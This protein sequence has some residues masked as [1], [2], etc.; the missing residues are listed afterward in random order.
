MQFGIGEFLFQGDD[1]GGDIPIAFFS[2]KM[3]GA[4]LNY[5]VTEKEFLAAVKIVERFRPY[6]ELMLSTVIMT[7]KDVSGRPARRSLALQSFNF[8]F[9]NRKEKD[10]TVRSGRKLC[11]RF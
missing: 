10:N 11:D 6:V 1:S 3:R 7:L 8:N 2:A 4:Q 5:T 9:E